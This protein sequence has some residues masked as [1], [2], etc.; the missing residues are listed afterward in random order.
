[1]AQISLTLNIP[2]DIAAQE[3]LDAFC[4]EYGYKDS[5]QGLT[6]RQFVKREVIEFVI[7]PWADKE[8]NRAL[9]ESLLTANGR[10]KVVKSG[11]T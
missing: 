6:Q 11:I 3:I 2:D 1:M 10:I 4:D 8:K 9:K 7:R 5:G